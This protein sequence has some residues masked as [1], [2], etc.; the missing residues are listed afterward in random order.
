MGK[1]IQALVSEY[2]PAAMVV[3]FSIFFS[4]WGSFYVAIKLGFDVEGAAES[5]GTILAAYLA[6]KVTQ[7]LRIAATFALTPIVAKV[8]HRFYPPVPKTSEEGSSEIPAEM[9]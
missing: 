3:Y 4:V 7:P 5:S 1:K 9:L 2:G 6:T 8:W